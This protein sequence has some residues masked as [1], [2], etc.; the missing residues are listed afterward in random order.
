MSALLLL[1]LQHTESPAW[2][3]LAEKYDLDHD[4]RIVMNEYARNSTSFGRLDRDRDG[5][6][7][8]ADFSAEF[9]ALWRDQYL[10]EEELQDHFLRSCQDDAA[11]ELRRDEF[12]RRI[13]SADHDADA[14]L[15]AREFEALAPGEDAWTRLEKSL[16]PDGDGHVTRAELEAAFDRLDINRDGELVAPGLRDLVLPLQPED[17]PLALIF[18]SFT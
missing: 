16:D 6:L 14:R 5:V 2:N 1:L 3:Y 17:K 18:G 9:A 7:T 10:Q 4:G 12:L 8:L 11:P 13:H 15:S